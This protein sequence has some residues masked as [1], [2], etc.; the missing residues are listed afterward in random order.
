MGVDIRTCVCVCVCVC[1]CLR[2]RVSNLTFNSTHTLLLRPDY[3]SVHAEVQTRTPSRCGPL[4]KEE[5]PPGNMNPMLVA[6]QARPTLW[7]CDTHTCRYTLL[8]LTPKNFSRAAL[9]GASLNSFFE[10][11]RA[12]QHGTN[13]PLTTPVKT[14][15]RPHLS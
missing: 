4:S 1:V 2:T 11:R 7:Y 3:Y 15:L 14:T 9:I 12:V 13:T 5:N 10:L 6:A 8:S